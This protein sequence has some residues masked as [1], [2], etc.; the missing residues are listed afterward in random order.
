[1]NRALVACLC[2]KK[3]AKSWKAKAAEKCSLRWE[4]LST[5]AGNLR[6][7]LTRSHPTPR[8]H[9]E[10]PKAHSEQWSSPW[11]CRR[12]LFSRGGW[13]NAGHYK[14]ANRTNLG[15]EENIPSSS[16]AKRCPP[17]PHFGGSTVPCSYFVNLKPWSGGEGSSSQHFLFPK[18]P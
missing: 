2:W 11:R 13:K 10:I 9:A 12:L 18:R 15:K 3:A 4:R 6:H 1:M 17:L 14:G 7:M 16:Q 5:T 8:H